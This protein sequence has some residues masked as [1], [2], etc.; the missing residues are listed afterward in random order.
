M[1]W[2]FAACLIVQQ[3][4]SYGYV[5]DSNLNKSACKHCWSQ[6]KGIGAGEVTI[7]AAQ[8]L[9]VHTLFRFRMFLW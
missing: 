1:N 5:E 4:S 6:K 3:P 2:H 7:F 8:G 9:R